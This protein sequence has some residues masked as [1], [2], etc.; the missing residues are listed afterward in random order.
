MFNLYFRFYQ[1]VIKMVSPLLPW[2]EPQLIEGSNSVLK[3]P[4]VLKGLGLKN[5]LIVT[6]KTIAELGL[7]SDLLDGLNKQ[8]ISYIVYDKTIPNPTID[9]IEEALDQ[10]RTNN[11]D[12]IIAFGGGSPIDCA[13]IVG[14]RVVKPK[15]SIAK[16]KGILKIRKSTPPFFAVPT[17]AGTGSECTLA[18]VISNPKTHEKYPINDTALIPNYAV[19]DPNLT[20]GLPKHITATTGLDALTH[21]IEAYI[22]KSNTKKTLMW[23]ENA[24][25]LIF[26]NLYEAYQNGQNI[27]ARRNMLKAS[28]YAGLSFTRAYVGNVHAIAHTLGGFYSVPHGLANSIILPVVL[29]YYG[30][31]VHKPLA[32]LAKIVNIGSEGDTEKELA[33]KFIDSINDLNMKMNIPSTIQ[34]I[35][36][37]DIPLMIKRAYKESN[38][39]YPV[40]MIFTKSDFNNIYNLLKD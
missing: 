8:N 3:L 20:L 1:K 11:C 12:S 19:L 36:I 39:L 18:A 10:Y 28:Y 7:M 34:E 16:M 29:E 37:S 13:K 25:K 35:Q 30:K 24:V 33:E 15:I 2:R 32:H 14:A 40:P 23:S 26:E 21:A 31:S 5:V 22:G 38:P 4:C 6:D 27:D 9:N 17:T